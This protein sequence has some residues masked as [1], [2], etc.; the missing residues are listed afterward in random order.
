MQSQ[1]IPLSSEGMPTHALCSASFRTVPCHLAKSASLPI[2]AILVWLGI[3]R[4]KL[5]AAFNL[6]G[7][8]QFRTVLYACFQKDLVLGLPMHRKSGS[9]R[10][11]GSSR[12]RSGCQADVGFRRRH[13]W[14]SQLQRKSCVDG[15]CIAGPF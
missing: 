15:S 5:G 7:S 13:R 14:L 3:S 4:I 10:P 2:A 12:P 1:T 6:P 11:F 9:A 8:L